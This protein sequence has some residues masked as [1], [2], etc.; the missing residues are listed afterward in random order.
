VL[1]GA[2]F[3]LGALPLSAPAHATR[4]TD[5]LD[6]SSDPRSNAE[7]NGIG[8]ATGQCPTPMGGVSNNVQGLVYGAVVGQ[9]CTS[10]QRYVFGQT[11]GGGTTVCSGQGSS[12]TWVMSIPL[13]GTRPLGSSC[14]AGFAQA[15]QTPDGIPVVCGESGT[16]VRN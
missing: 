7:I 14:V 3:P 11:A 8:A 9:P 2:A 15:A 13:I 4:C 1:A 16:W 10:T 5:Q 6:Y 12:G